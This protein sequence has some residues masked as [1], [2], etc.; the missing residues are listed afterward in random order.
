MA[1]DD[2]LLSA[3][4]GAI[5]GAIVTVTASHL[6]RNR[7]DRFAYELNNIYKPL[8]AEFSKLSRTDKYRL[9]VGDRYPWTPSEEFRKLEDR[10][11]LLPRRFRDLWNDIQGVK[12]LNRNVETRSTEL[13]S[14]VET[15]LT[16]AITQS[17]GDKRY[18]SMLMDPQFAQ[19][20]KDRLF[21][22]LY[23]GRKEDFDEWLNVQQKDWK[24]F[25]QIPIIREMVSV[26][27][28][29]TDSKVADKRR[30]FIVAREALFTHIDLVL[31]RLGKVI[32][33]GGRWRYRRH[34]FRDVPYALESQ[35][36]RESKK[37]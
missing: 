13:W 30:G 12:C 26:V 2:N 22:P 16:E 19:L 17:T 9:E 7:S 15:R 21:I 5:A 33:G 6:L 35:M 29:E 25:K 4:M 11:E 31:I 18:K 36:I 14:L 24:Y 37:P 28:K 10:G 27:F 23:F 32:Q 20:M 34:R 3:A 1:I 8:R